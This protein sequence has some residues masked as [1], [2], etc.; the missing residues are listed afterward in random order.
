MTDPVPIRVT[1]SQFRAG[2]PAIDYEIRNGG[3]TVVADEDGRV[4][5]HVNI[6][7]DEL[8]CTDEDC[9]AAKAQLAEL[10]ASSGLINWAEDTRLS[11]KLA[12][13]HREASANWER[14]QMETAR[15]RDTA[16][17]QLR[18]ALAEVDEYKQHTREAYEER[19]AAIARAEH[20]E[21]ERDNYRSMLCD[22]LAESHR[23][24]DLSDRWV[25]TRD[26]LKTGQRRR[27]Y[28]PEAGRGRP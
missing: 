7:S 9:V 3:V 15:E 12:K 19:D 24:A 2:S 27:A 8:H 18:I 14:L 26:L 25:E 6:P 13:E 1:F 28:R 23:G 5:F 4:L 10:R 20:S 16:T 11:A 21:A 17:H 22:L